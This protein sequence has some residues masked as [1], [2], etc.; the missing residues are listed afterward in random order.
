MR[1][2]ALKSFLAGPLRAPP[3][4][5]RAS[6]RSHNWNVCST[7]RKGARPAQR[8]VQQTPEGLPMAP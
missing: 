8:G 7:A 3:A 1:G 6:A 5:S 2:A 4:I